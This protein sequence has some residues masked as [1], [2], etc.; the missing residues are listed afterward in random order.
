MRTN[1][2][3]IAAA[4]PNG[5]AETQSP[6]GAG[7]LTLDGVL[8]S[9]NQDTGLPEWIA[10]VPRVIKVTSDADDS[11]N[12]FT[13]TGE[14]Q[15]GQ[16]VTED[17]AGPDG[18]PTSTDGTT[19]FRRIISIAIDGAAVGDIIVGTTDAVNTP[20]IPLNQTVSPVQHTM[21]DVQDTSVTPTATDHADLT[22]KTATD[23]GNYA[24]PVRAIRVE[25]TSFTAGTVQFGYTQAGIS[26]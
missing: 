12:I 3:T 8:V 11:G 9:T 5:I 16:V 19:L 26:C 13:V 18:T 25:M 23:D 10:D 6:A 24:F 15:L 2:L 20:W 14:N 21:D 22:A 17:I 4:D 7:N 1:S